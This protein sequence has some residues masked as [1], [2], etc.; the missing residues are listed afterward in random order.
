MKDSIVT[1]KRKWVEI[2]TLIVCF[3]LSNGLNLYS[4]IKYDT[5]YNEL[6]WSLGFVLITTIALYMLW[7]LIRALFY[8]ILGIFRYLRRQ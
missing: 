4:I 5:P 7:S 1:A 8:L 3:V 2:W 6:F